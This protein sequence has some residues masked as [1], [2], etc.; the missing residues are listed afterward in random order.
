MNMPRVRL[1]A[2]L[3]IRINN[4]KIKI[5]DRFGKD[6]SVHEKDVRVIKNTL[7]QLGYYTPYDKTGITG[8]PD[9]EVF[10]AL[11]QFQKDQNLPAT[12]ALKPE[13][14]TVRALDQG[15]SRKPKGRYIWRTS[16]GQDACCTHKAQA[17]KIRSWG[18][19]LDPTDDHDCNCWAEPISDVERENLPAIKDI[20]PLIPGTNIP[21]RGVPEQGWPGARKFD[22]F[23]PGVTGEEDRYIE[24]RPSPIDPGIIVP[25]NPKR[26]F[27]KRKEWNT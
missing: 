1:V 15:V 14:D 19:G 25:Y 16:S 20:E 12:G 24:R 4:M 23:K 18:H 21:D 7:N 27:V 8:F 5:H 17:G 11:K 26:S 2:F 9:G 3:L 22:P 13:D 6:S 10:T